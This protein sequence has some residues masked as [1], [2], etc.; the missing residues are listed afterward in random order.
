MW[1][2]L[3]GEEMAAGTF[4]LID[5][6]WPLPFLNGLYELLLLVP[7][8]VFV[9][10]P[11]LPRYASYIDRYFMYFTHQLS[12]PAAQLFTI[13]RR[14]GPP[15]QLKPRCLSGFGLRLQ[16]PRRTFTLSMC[17]WYKRLISLTVCSIIAVN[18]I[19]ADPLK[20][21][22]TTRDHQ[23]YQWV[24]RLAQDEIPSARVLVYDHL[25][26]A[27]RAIE[28]EAVDHPEHKAS[29]KAYA[30][31]QGRLSEFGIEEWTERFV[32]ALH[33]WRDTKAVCSY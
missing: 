9:T 17:L 32:Q 30:A 14:A 8:G 26:P 21:W 19:C 3:L 7:L 24:Q 13:L 25:L 28:I 12:R 11:P 15:D 2:P 29:A 5:S 33:S 6:S 4:F 1:G 22:N 27:E 10:L 31:V 16:R 20:T 23:P 18:A